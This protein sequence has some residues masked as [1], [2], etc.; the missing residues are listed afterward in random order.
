MTRTDFLAENQTYLNESSLHVLEAVTDAQFDA[1][2]AATEATNNLEPGLDNSL[3]RTHETIEDFE[4][5]RQSHW[6]ECRAA[7]RCEFAGYPAI[8]YRGVQM[9]R[10]QPRIH[11]LIVVDFGD[12]R[13][14]LH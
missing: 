10:G 13:V 11:D 8:H 1:L 2:V 3:V 5:S 6:T 9:F 12:F 4:N 14:S 7:H